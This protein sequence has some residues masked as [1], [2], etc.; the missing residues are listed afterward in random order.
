MDKKKSARIFLLVLVGLLFIGF[1]EGVWANEWDTRNPSV[2]KFTTSIHGILSDGYEAIRPLLEALLMGKTDSPESFFAKII[3]ALILFGII[4]EVM[5]KANFFDNKWAKYLIS[6]AVPIL[7]IRFL[8]PEWVNTILLP[9]STMGVAIAAMIPLL[10]YFTFVYKAIRSRTLRKIAW[11]FAAV[12]FTGLFFARVNDTQ[13]GNAIWIYP[14]TAIACI[15]FMIFDGTIRSKWEKAK[16]ESQKEEHRAKQ[17]SKLIT[18]DRTIE[19]KW[20]KGEYK[21]NWLDYKNDK[22]DLAKRAQVFKL[23][24]DIPDKPRV[25]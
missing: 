22:S 3:L 17:I 15:I 16:T 24:I 11:I 4:Y 14:V 1:I 8:E 6:I 23:K 18:E 19:E 2:S 25:G 12:I 7:A 13:L 21:D 5:D 10:I 20:A 9:Y